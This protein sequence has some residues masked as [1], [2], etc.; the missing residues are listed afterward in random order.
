[1]LVASAAGLL[2]KTETTLTS[3]SPA[4]GVSTAVTPVIVPSGAVITAV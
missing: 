4:S 1:M 2:G 3:A